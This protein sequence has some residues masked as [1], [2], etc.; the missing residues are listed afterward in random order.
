MTEV[1]DNKMGSIELY[2]GPMFSGKSSMLIKT[3]KIYESIGKKILAIN[4]KRD[5]RYGINKITTHDKISINCVM[6]E[7]LNDIHRNF[8]KEFKEADI[9]LVEELQFFD[10]IDFIINAAEKYGK[11]VVTSGLDGDFQRKPFKSV[12]NLIPYC[13]TVTKLRGFCKICRDGTPSLF[14]KRIVKST[15]NILVGG[16]DAYIGVCRK[17]YN[18]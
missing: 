1:L 11:K 18:E 13:D 7:K 15:K 6:V 4:N 16:S 3:A 5:T 8:S 12:V 10:D 9:I 2:I 14:S 17:H